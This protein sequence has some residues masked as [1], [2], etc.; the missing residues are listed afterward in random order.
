M[1]FE[2]SPSLRQTAWIGHERE[3]NLA[4]F[5]IVGWQPKT[6]CRPNRDVRWSFDAFER[7]EESFPFHSQTAVIMGYGREEN[8]A[9]LNFDCVRGGSRGRFSPTEYIIFPFLFRRGKRA[10]TSIFSSVVV[11]VVF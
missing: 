2:L 9:D 5:G 1:G 8:F 11:F 3:K 6:S 4:A 10:S 7:R